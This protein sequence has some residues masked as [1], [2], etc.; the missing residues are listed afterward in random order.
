[1]E[2]TTTNYTPI[3]QLSLVSW[4]IGVAIS[5]A[6]SLLQWWTTGVPAMD[7]FLTSFLTQ[8]TLNLIYQRRKTYERIDG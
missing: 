4:S 5:I 6:S 1:M 8:I 2:R 7:A 3:P